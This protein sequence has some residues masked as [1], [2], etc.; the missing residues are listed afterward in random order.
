MTHL[1]TAGTLALLASYFTCPERM[2]FITQGRRR[3]A[4]IRRT[5]KG[6]G[7]QHRRPERPIHC[8]EDF[9][10]PESER[11]LDAIADAL[12]WPLVL[13]AARD[14]DEAEWLANQQGRQ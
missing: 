3:S 5:T 8:A 7:C 2:A 11:V 9:S 4:R 6:T 10:D 12:L 13:Q 14:D 1:T